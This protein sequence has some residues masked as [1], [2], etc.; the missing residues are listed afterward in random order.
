MRGSATPTEKRAEIIVE[1]GLL[2][3]ETAAK[4]HGV[5]KN[6][7]ARWLAA[8]ESDEQLVQLVRE[9]REAANDAWAARVPGC[10]EKLLASIER[11]AE[12][13][14][15]RSPEMMYSLAGALKIVA[16][17]AVTWKILGARL[18]VRQAGRHGAQVIPFAAGG[19]GHG[20]NGKCAQG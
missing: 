11:I 7:V 20:G 1:A 10:I 9:K 14:Q 16:D 15:N 2:G 12:D 19:N 4:N 3:A 8:M 18:S 6:T 13:T 5:H 17:V